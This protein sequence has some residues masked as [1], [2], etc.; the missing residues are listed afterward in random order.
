V[1]KLRTRCFLRSFV[2]REEVVLTARQIEKKFLALLAQT[3]PVARAIK[4][5]ADMSRRGWPDQLV[6]LPGGHVTFVEFKGARPRTDEAPAPRDRG[7]EAPRS[8]RA[9][10]TIHT[11][12]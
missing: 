7:I 3:V 10:V 1:C 12:S 11:G 9:S 4:L 8:Q 2:G 6:V 5:S